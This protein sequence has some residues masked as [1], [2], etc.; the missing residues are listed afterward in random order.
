M[1]V[2]LLLLLISA[3]L[4]WGRYESYNES[5]CYV[6]EEM[7]TEVQSAIESEVS[8]ELVQAML[9]DMCAN[10]EALEDVAPVCEFLVQG[11]LPSV[12]E[13]TSTMAYELCPLLNL[14]QSYSPFQAR[15]QLR[16]SECTLCQ[17]AAVQYSK[18]PPV[19]VPP[20][21]T[22]MVQRHKKCRKDPARCAW[23][24]SLLVSHLFRTGEQSGV[25]NQL[26]SCA[27]RTKGDRLPMGSRYCLLCKVIVNQAQG[28]INSI[29]TDTFEDMIENLC[30]GLPEENG[31]KDDDGDN[32][33]KQC[34]ELKEKYSSVLLEILQKVQPATFCELF[35]VCSEL[36]N[37]R[38]AVSC[39]LCS[40]WFLF[41]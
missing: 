2:S 29:S 1:R 18:E 20:G 27:D 40:L 11:Y 3:P 5:L 38:A 15:K 25:C 39:R 7:V 33:Q 37:Q 12:M 35:S 31:G 6:C 28:N 22:E 34:E 26:E 16:L 32:L 21:L 8:R 30:E 41:R 10:A 9:E 24:V 17:M 36:T 4:L 19:R 23:G 14:C 13:I